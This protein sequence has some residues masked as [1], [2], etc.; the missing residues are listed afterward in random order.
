MSSYLKW[1]LKNYFGTKYKWFG[2][3]G[4]IYLLF[5]LVPE[6]SGKIFGLI[7][8]GYFIIIIICIYGIVFAGT[9]YTVQ[10]F[11]KKT[12]LLESM[13]PVSGKKILLAKYLLGIII[14]LVYTAWA[15]L[16]I[17][18]FGFKYGG[19]EKLYDY[20]KDFLT[21]FDV[22]TLFRTFSAIFSTSLFILS[23]VIMCYVIAK[24]MNPA[25]KYDKII[26]FIL[27]YV[28]LYLISSFIVEIRSEI[29]SVYFLDLIFILISA[30]AFYITSYF[31][32]NK[33]EIY[34]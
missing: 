5:L 34:S 31:V 23:V 30:I 6:S 32:E 33:L 24:A 22:V 4:I 13:I 21:N 14:N 10:T 7:G 8:S 12:F 28:A 20:L 19:F 26:G 29:S 27:A 25:G 2:L 16:G 3:F 9:K 17:I 11:S 15:I 18:V 1:E